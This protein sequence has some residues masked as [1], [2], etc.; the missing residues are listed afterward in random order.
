[1]TLE[2]KLIIARDKIIGKSLQYTV[3]KHFRDDRAYSYAAEIVNS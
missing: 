3:L 2:T 1:M